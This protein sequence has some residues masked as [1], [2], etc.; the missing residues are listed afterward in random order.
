MQTKTS[1]TGNAR[2]AKSNARAFV[3]LVAAI[4]LLVY[5]WLPFNFV[6]AAVLGTVGE[7]RTPAD[8][9][10]DAYAG[11]LPYP[12]PWWVGA[13]LVLGLATL[14]ASCW[15]PEHQVHR[16][17]AGIV[18]S[19]VRLGMVAF[20][21]LALAVGSIALSLYYTPGQPFSP[22]FFV[23]AGAVA[24]AAAAQL[25]KMRLTR[26]DTDVVLLSDLGSRG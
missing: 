21:A 15:K 19:E 25:R 17:A 4:V 1:G 8:T 13:L 14:V 9:H 3:L 6:M 23:A 16:N 26:K 20:L 7:G 18:V 24:V 12:T 11:V 10:L 2:V 22:W 5:I